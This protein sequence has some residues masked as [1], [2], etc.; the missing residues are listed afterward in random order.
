[1]ERCEVCGMTVHHDRQRC[2]HCS[3]LDQSFD[4]LLTRNPK[5]AVRWAEAKV[6]QAEMKVRF[7]GEADDN[8]TNPRDDKA[9]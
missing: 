8:G 3:D 5:A 1:M 9:V 6:L 4:R 7:K 2:F